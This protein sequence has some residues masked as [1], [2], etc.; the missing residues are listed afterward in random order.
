MAVLTC[1][2]EATQNLT[3]KGAKSTHSWGYLRQQ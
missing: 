2:V 3:E 1:L